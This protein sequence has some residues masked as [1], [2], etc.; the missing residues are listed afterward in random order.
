MT[1]KDKWADW[2]QVGDRYF[3]E[4][5]YCEALS[6]YTNGVQINPSNPLLLSKK[7]NTLYMLQQYEA[8]DLCYAEA[9]NNSNAI[10]IVYEYVLEHSNDVEDNLWWL[11]EVLYS[12]HQLEII[13]EGLVRIVHQ[14][15]Q[16]VLEQVNRSTMNKNQSFSWN[17]FLDMILKH[18]GIPSA[19]SFLGLVRLLQQNV[20]QKSAGILQKKPVSKM[21]WQQ[22]E[23]FIQW[24]FEKQGYRVQKTKKSGD[25]GA[26]L[27]LEQP[28]ERVVVQVKKRKKLRGTKQYRKFLLLLGSTKLTE[29][30]SS[31]PPNSANPLW[32]LPTGLVSNS[33]IGNGFSRR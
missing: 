7:G 2:M 3:Q 6:A 12:Q 33:G 14:V 32:N 19:G 22:F 31:P 13:D 26:D 30:S 1:S 18:L 11:Q 5:H 9:L 24:F 10:V 28:G 21:T 15:G 23:L 4:G 29:Q 27:I 25:Q 16:E 20:S 17:P 8:A